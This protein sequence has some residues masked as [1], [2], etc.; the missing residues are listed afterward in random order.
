VYGR[1]G[2]IGLIWVDNTHVFLLGLVVR[3]V[4]DCCPSALWGFAVFL[5]FSSLSFRER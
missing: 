5:L 2:G 1:M 4:L 3:L